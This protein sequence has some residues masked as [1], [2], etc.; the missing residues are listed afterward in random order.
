M[1]VFNEDRFALTSGVGVHSF[2]PGVLRLQMESCS[3]SESGGSK[4]S[5]KLVLQ[6]VSPPARLT[7]SE[8]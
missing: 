6:R 8:I 2:P 3:G 4:L 7:L 1:N 5:D